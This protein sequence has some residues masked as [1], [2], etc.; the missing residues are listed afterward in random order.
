MS[1]DHR[2]HHPVRVA[3][4][5]RGEWPDEAV[6]AISIL[7]PVMQP[8]PG[9]EIN[10]LSLLAHHP[11]LAHEVLSLSLYLRFRSTM[12]DRTRELLILRTAWLRG[13]RYELLRHARLARRIGFTDEELVRIARG[14]A[15]PGW[16][17]QEA[18]LLR[19]VD[20]LCR[21]YRVADATWSELAELHTVRE[22]MDILF[23][24][25]TYNMLAMAYNS[26]GL[27]PEADLPPF[28]PVD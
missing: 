8:A 3:P 28:P 1:D 23:T 9:Q 11:E 26:M 5:P 2:A 6:D 14:P 19:A 22:L 21:D 13:A 27:Q 20:E 25:G 12:S 18:L 17:P 10:S 16:E 24:V 4:L 15:A 7:P